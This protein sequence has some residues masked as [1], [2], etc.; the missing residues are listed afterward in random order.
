MRVRIACNAVVFW[1]A[2]HFDKVGT[3]LD[4]NSETKRRPREFRSEA[5]RGATGEGGEGIIYPSSI[6]TPPHPLFLIEHDGEST[7]SRDN[8]HTENA[9]TVG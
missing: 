7:R 8:I 5:E 9:C 1:R 6:P 4:S 3:I 2:T